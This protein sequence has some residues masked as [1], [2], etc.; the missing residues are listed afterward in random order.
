MFNNIGELM[1][2]LLIRTLLLSLMISVLPLLANPL[3]NNPVHEVS[4]EFNKQLMCMAKNIYYEAGM[5]PYEGKLAV[6]AVVMNRVNNPNFPKTVC[7]VVYQKVN[8]TYQFSWVGENKT[9]SPNKYAWEE[10]L[11]VAKKAMTGQ[12]LHDIISKTKALYF[13]ATSIKPDWNHRKVAQIGNH[14]FYASK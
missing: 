14:I 4:Y 12:V 2:F 13:H 7:D 3:T 1:K 11:I 6:A 10:S 5:E 8:S 9:S